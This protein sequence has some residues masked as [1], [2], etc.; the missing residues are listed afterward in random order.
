MCESLSDRTSHIKENKSCCW[1]FSDLLPQLRT[2]D[3]IYSHLQSVAIGTHF[4]SQTKENSH[5]ETVAG[6]RL[7]AAAA[8]PTNQCNQ[9][10]HNIIF[11]M[12]I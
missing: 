7:T 10:L 11:A 1:L 4:K 6:K 8:G 5:Y 3:D 12:T 9:V 2:N